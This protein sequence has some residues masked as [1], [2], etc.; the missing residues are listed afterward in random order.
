MSLAFCTYL[1]SLYVLITSIL[2]DTTLVFSAGVLN[3]RLKNKFQN[4]LQ[5][6]ELRFPVKINK[7]NRLHNLTLTSYNK[8]EYST[9]D[10]II[11]IFIYFPRSRLSYLMK[12]SMMQII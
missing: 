5:N 1:M 9:R 6:E 10:R 12:K 11:H 2:V 3:K 4:F 7:I 8:L